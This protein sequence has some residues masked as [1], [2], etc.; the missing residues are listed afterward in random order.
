M[1]KTDSVKKILF[2]VNCLLLIAVWIYTVIYWFELPETVAIHFGLDGKADGFGSKNM[3]FLLAGINTALFLLL[4]LVAKNP[5]APG[6]NIPDYLRKNK[7]LAE[8]FT[9][10]IL[11]F[12]MLLFADLAY[13]S[14]R[15]SLGK[16][17]ELSLA[18]VY[19]LALMFIYMF[20]F[21]FFAY[22]AEKKLKP[23]VEKSKGAKI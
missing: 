3:N 14:N 21:F 13:E 10:G 22:H 7:P 12:V 20:A 8:L 23:E 11:F 4:N 6:V 18:T 5:D 1:K 15:V 2:L 17:Q 9:Q 19:I 16:Q